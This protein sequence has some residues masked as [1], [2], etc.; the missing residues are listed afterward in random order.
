MK[1][2]KVKGLVPTK[3][4]YYLL[5]LPFSMF[6]V[7]LAGFANIFYSSS[8]EWLV[9]YSF[10]IGLGFIVVYFVMESLGFDLT[11]A[12]FELGLSNYMFYAPMSLL[13]I[14]MQERKFDF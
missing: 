2:N 7:A 13:S 9:K 6:F 10:V 11:V 12:T 3:Y 4:Q 1:K 14:K 8:P 5:L